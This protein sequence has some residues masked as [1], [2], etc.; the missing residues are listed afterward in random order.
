MTRTVRHGLAAL[1]TACGLIGAAALIEPGPAAALGPGQVCVFNAP[2]GG[3]GWIGHDG[4]GYLIG[5][6]NQWIYGATENYSGARQINPGHDIGYWDRVG[7]WNQMVGTFSDPSIPTLNHIH[8][9]YYTTYKCYSTSTSS[10]GAANAARHAARCGGYD[11]ITNNSLHAVYNVL[12]TYNGSI[13]MPAPTL[14][15]PNVWYT[16]LGQQRAPAFPGW[17]SAT[18]LPGPNGAGAGSDPGGSCP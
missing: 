5:G 12:H 10:V 11:W 3:N 16:E 1:L 4:W 8:R 7:N 17:S 2:T 15:S 13:P 18:N 6:T 9:N 14:S